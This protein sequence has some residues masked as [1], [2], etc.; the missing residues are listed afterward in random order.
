MN[1]AGFHTQERWLEEGFW[2]TE[3]FVANGDNLTI[4][5]FIGF[6]QG[7]GGSCSCHFLF[8][9]KS[10]IAK[11]FLDVTDNFTFSSGGERVASL[12]KD[13]HE[14]VGELTSSQ[15]QTENGMWESI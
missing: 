12:G 4:G 13:L 1:S 14:V 7:G 15:V 5:Q 3:S 10:N 11:L 2:G 6:L 8:E 9:V